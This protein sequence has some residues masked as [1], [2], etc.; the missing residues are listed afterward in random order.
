M[1]DMAELRERQRIN[2]RLFWGTSYNGAIREHVKHDMGN[3]ST[4]RNTI[5]GRIAP[6]K[7]EEDHRW[8]R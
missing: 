8:R 4:S 5:V 7:T 2:I 6:F 1:A 3:A